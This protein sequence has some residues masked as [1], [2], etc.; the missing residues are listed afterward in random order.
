MLLSLWK[1]NVTLL[2]ASAGIA[3]VAVALAAKETL[4]NFFGNVTVLLDRPYK[5]GDYIILD[6]GERG[7]VV[8]IG[9]R[10]TRCIPRCE[11][12]SELV[13]LIT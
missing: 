8:E 4:S 9:M 3:G 1:I 11:S 5:V 2:L 12:L 6:S 7:E 13:F 10:S